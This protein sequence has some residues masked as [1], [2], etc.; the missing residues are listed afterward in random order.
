VSKKSFL[1]RFLKEHHWVVI[2][3]L[4]IVAY[5]LGYIGSVKQF[6]ATG[7]ERSFLDPFY[8]PLQLFLM[9]D[10]MVV[11][12]PVVSWE[13]EVARFLAPVVAAYTALV[14]L[15]TL[16]RDQI[17]IFRLRF[18]RGHTVICGL[19]QK[20]LQLVKDFNNHG[21]QVVVIEVDEDNDE[22]SSCREL[23]I[24]VLIGDAKDEVLLRKARVYCAKYVVAITGDDGTNIEI[25]MLTHK[26]VEKRKASL[27]GV[28]QCFVHIVDFKLCTL[29]SRHRIFTNTEDAFEISVFNV[30]E[31]SARVMLREHPLDR[32]GISAEDLRDVHLVVAG[33]GQ[34]GE[35]IVLQA[36]RIAHFAN[37][38]KLRITVIDKI[39]EE[40]MRSFYGRYPQFDKVCEIVFLKGDIE[41][42]E[43]IE[44]ICEWAYDEKNVTSAA[45]TFNNDAQSLSCA[46]NI[47]SRLHNSAIPIA[48]RMTEENG[49]GMLLESD[50]KGSDRLNYIYPFGMIGL[51]CT[52][53][54]LVNEKLNLLAKA[55]HTDYVRKAK[56]DGRPENDLSILSWEQLHPDLKSSNLQ[57]ADHIPVKLRAIGY[58]SSRPEIGKSPVTAFADEEVELMAKMEHARFNAE[59]FLAGWTIGPKNIEEKRSPYLVPWEELPENIKEYDRDTVRKIPHRLG[60]IGEVIYRE[61]DTN[62]IDDVG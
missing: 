2:G 62:S 8:R 54:I 47:I 31:N 41:N 16:F 5:V 56:A 14:A 40:K 51:I 11:L 46:L 58:Y 27:S 37:D 39:A 22:I 19:G 60:L 17:K 21:D 4:W 30:Y 9:D 3:A 52:R 33:F 18:V 35:S 50:V 24:P 10:S 45:V 15:L 34:M 7:E 38:K 44:K 36:A 42:T 57:Q 49:L 12:G 20:G 43:I 55:I 32:S 61:S 25:A 23:G 59:R 26:L 53:E 29:L 6:A 13:L 48:V 28:V 1:K